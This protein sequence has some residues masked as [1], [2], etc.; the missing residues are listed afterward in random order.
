M[1]SE[2]VVNYDKYKIQGNQKETLTYVGLV[3]I[4]SVPRKYKTKTN[5]QWCICHLYVFVFWS[6]GTILFLYRP[7]WKPWRL[8][9]GRNPL[10]KMIEGHVSHTSLISIAG[11][12]VTLHHIPSG[13]CT[14]NYVITLHT[15]L[16]RH[17]SHV[18]PWQDRLDRFW[19]GPW[20][21]EAGTLGQLLA[22]V[23]SR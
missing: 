11:K 22:T 15:P 21:Q 14:T 19:S 3:K 12:H 6:V 17:V 10:Y 16:T 20:R 2:Y 7:R 4:C 8:Q 9:G 23:P 18:H 5:K 13:L 1:N